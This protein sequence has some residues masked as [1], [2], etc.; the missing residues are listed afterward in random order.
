MR[1]DIVGTPTG[2]SI[3]K[4]T[5]EQQKQALTRGLI[6]DKAHAQY[7]DEEIR[8]I[9]SSLERREKCHAILLGEPGVGKTTILKGIAQRIVAND[10]TLPPIFRNKRI[11]SIDYSSLTRQI[12]NNYQFDEMLQQRLESILSEAKSHKESVIL[13]IDEVHAFFM[14][15]P[16]N[17]S[18]AETLK[19]ALA[20]GSITIMGATT[21]ME[22]KKLINENPALE[23]RL[24]TI[25]IKEPPRAEVKQILGKVAPFLEARHGVQITN[26]AIEE[27]DE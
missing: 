11:F 15:R 14:S 27:A 25:E 8:Q 9:A 4:P 24:P 5:A 21:T 7:T 13:F 19:P 20:D 22:Y 18:L 12:P 26:E 2:R 6:G 10:P 17:R 16:G 3:P 1:P 23:R